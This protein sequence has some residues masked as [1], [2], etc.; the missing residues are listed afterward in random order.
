MGRKKNLRPIRLIRNHPTGT[1]AEGV[2]V[3]Y[4]YIL[5]FQ[6]SAS[7]FLRLIPLPFF[8]TSTFS[9]LRL[10]RVR[11][12]PV[13]VAFVPADTEYTLFMLPNQKKCAKMKRTRRLS[14]EEENEANC[15][16]NY[17]CSE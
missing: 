15:L 3:L 17:N 6:S 9:F 10:L 14:R 5:P 7:Y 12:F 11:P 13:A 1:L 2:P 8:L 16:G 4:V